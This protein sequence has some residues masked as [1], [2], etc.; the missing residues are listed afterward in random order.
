MVARGWGST[1]AVYES[2]AE[3]QGLLKELGQPLDWD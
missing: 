2:V 3:L 1:E